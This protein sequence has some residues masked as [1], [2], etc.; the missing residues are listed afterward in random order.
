MKCLNKVLGHHETCV[1][2]MSSTGG[3]SSFGVLMMLVEVAVQHV[4]PKSPI[5]LQLMRSGDCKGHMHIIK[6]PST[7]KTCFS[8]GYIP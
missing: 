1:I 3:F 5:E 2:L 4:A 7:Q 6:T 8:Y